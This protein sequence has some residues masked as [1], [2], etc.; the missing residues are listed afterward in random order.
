MLTTLVVALI[1]VSIVAIIFWI[2][3]AKRG[4]R[5]VQLR[6]E[7]GKNAQKSAGLD[8]LEAGFMIKAHGLNGEP[9]T[10]EARRK[11]NNRYGSWQVSITGLR[12]GPRVECFRD[13]NLL[14]VNGI[15]TAVLKIPAS[16]KRD[17]T[18]P[19]VE[20]VELITGWWT[21]GSK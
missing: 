10:I 18:Y 8:T 12:D 14:V 1:I 17:H 4:N 5:I 21:S 2:G 7:I 13:V 20:S 16:C 15:L 19:G 9:V 3:Y 11:A 6:G